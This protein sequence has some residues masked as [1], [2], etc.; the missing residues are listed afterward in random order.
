[1]LST[2]SLLEYQKFL[3]MLR[4][5]NT[6]QPVWHDQVE[7]SQQNNRNKTILYAARISQNAPVGVLLERLNW[8]A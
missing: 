1:M 3:K 4:I 6:D 8:F 5:F 2:S 7:G